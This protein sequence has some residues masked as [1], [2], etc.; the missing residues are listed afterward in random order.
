[1]QKS[2][3]NFYCEFCDYTC[4]TKF[5]W[6]Q[7]CST[8]KHNRKRFGNPTSSLHN[9]QKPVKK[10]CK[11]PTKNTPNR[12]KKICSLSNSDLDT[13]FMCDACGKTYKNR[14]GLWKHR[15]RCEAYISNTNTSTATNT[16]A[17]MNSEDIT[18]SQENHEASLLAKENN[19]LKELVH[20][21]IEHDTN[22]REQMMGQIAHQNK[23]IQ[24]MIPKIGNNNNNRFN[25]NVFLNE[26]C[27]DAINLSDFV[28]SL[29]VKL[30]DLQ[31]TSNNG[32]IEGISS[33]LVD[34]LKQLDQCKRPIHCTDVKREVLY[35]KDNNEWNRGDST[36]PIRSAI[37]D[38]ATKQRKAI[39]EWEKLN[40][41]WDT[42]EQGREEYIRI[43]KSVMADVNIPQDENRIIR[44]IAKETVINKQTGK[45][46]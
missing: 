31:Y 9:S 41:G 32:L 20:K 11:P 21:M 10:I 15:Q 4:S 22:T 14:G 24:D 7:H 36:A 2:K 18:V 45:D 5:L 16:T 30:A 6:N 19:E 26:N 28:E 1:M 23:I 42:S 44:N 39:A 46:S 34:G 35:I 38:V 3:N 27:R 12:R 8:R 43:V 29:H 25:I 40:P 37:V 17:S 13:R 33:V